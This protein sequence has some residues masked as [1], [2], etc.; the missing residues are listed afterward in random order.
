MFRNRRINY[1]HSHSLKGDSLIQLADGR[2]ISYYF[3][4]FGNLSIYHPDTFKEIFSI[5]PKDM[6]IRKENVEKEIKSYDEDED[7]V[8]GEE[9]GPLI[10]S[11]IIEFENNFILIS[12]RQYL[13][14]IHLLEENKYDG[15]VVYKAKENILNVNKLSEG[16]LIVITNQSLI[17]L[18]KE[19]N[20][21]IEKDTFL[22]KNNWR[23]VAISK[24]ERFYGNFKQYYSSI[25]LPNN[26][27]LLNSFSTELSYHG[28]CGT[29]PPE[30]FTRSKVIFI[31]LNNFNEISITKNFDIA[32]KCIV[33][34]DTII[35]QEYNEIYIYNINTFQM[36][37]KINLKIGY[38]EEFYKYD[39]NHIISISNSEEKNSLY[40]Y[41]YEKNNLI[42][43]KEASNEIQFNKIIGW[44]GYS[45]HKYKDKTL[46]ILKD[47]RIIILCHGEVEVL[48]DPFS[49]K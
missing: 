45:I 8:E 19:D 43:V 40:L 34:K 39:S 10:E 48:D 5:D 36:I 7:E 24:T 46:F 30:E 4:S 20:K 22:M 3:R 37:N 9:F 33:L 2:I 32:V 14:E 44:N 13:I 27:L 38:S 26:K 23:M 6:I 47:K 15:S 21:F 41:K 35:I 29:H 11:S 17:I 49:Q 28:G 31:D 25:A 18:K 12:C 1:S 16:R 42:R